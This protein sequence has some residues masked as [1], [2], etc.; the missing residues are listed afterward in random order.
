[1]QETHWRT[2]Y[3]VLNS[4]HVTRTIPPPMGRHSYNV[5]LN[6][7]ISLYMFGHAALSR[8]LDA[9][10]RTETLIS[11]QGYRGGGLPGG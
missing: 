3:L 5:I 10:G 9:Q 2:H 1:M 7:V 8:L 4:D 6:L 11:D